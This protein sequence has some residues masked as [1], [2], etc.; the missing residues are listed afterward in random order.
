MDP[1]PHHNPKKRGQMESSKCSNDRVETEGKRKWDRE[2]LE[3]NW[4]EHPDAP[5]HPPAELSP[6][7]VGCWLWLSPPE[8]RTRLHCGLMKSEACPT[9]GAARHGRQR[10]A[11]VLSP[12]PRTCQSASD[13][14]NVQRGSSG[15]NKSAPRARC[16]GVGGERNSV[17]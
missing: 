17:K 4:E 5:G 7:M 1:P 9:A 12:L 2:K 3:K 6:L 13:E 16:P 11:Q 14:K 8:P 15:V 10:R